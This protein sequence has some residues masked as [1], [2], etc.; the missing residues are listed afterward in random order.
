MGVLGYEPDLHD[1]VVLVMTGQVDLAILCDVS[2]SEMMNGE[3]RPT[4]TSGQKKASFLQQQQQ[5]GADDTRFSRT[6]PYHNDALSS[7]N[8]AQ[9]IILCFTCV[10]YGGKRSWNALKSGGAQH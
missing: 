10:M 6:A 5:H 2:L 3:A 1:F 9:V 8:N 7:T 4:E